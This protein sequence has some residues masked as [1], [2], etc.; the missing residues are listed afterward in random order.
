ME[1]NVFLSDR[2]SS[3]LKAIVYEF[4]ETGKPVGSRSFVQKYS[5]SISPATMRNIMFDLEKYG[6]LKQPHTS[7]GRI[8][9]DFGYRYYVDSLMQTYESSYDSEM[10]IKEDVLRREIQLDKMFVSIAKMLANV[11]KYAG[12]VLT[13]RADFTV[14]KY[15]ELVLLDTNE[16]LTVFVSRTGMILNKRVSVSE[17]L[18]QDNLHSYSKFLTSELS[19][20]SFKRIKESLLDSIRERLNN[21]TEYMIAVDIAE[22]SLSNCGEQDIYIE[23]IEN[24][25]H[26][27]E[28]LVDDRLKS[29][30]Y[31]IE[32][33]NNLKNII[34]QFYENDG[35]IT[36]IGEEIPDANVVDCS[37]ITSSYK[38][39]NNNVGALGIFGPTRMDYKKNLPLLDYTSK[40]VTTLLNKM[41]K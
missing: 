33:K 39:G 37:L 34:N 11:S 22:L 12:I 32:D 2:E 10:S 6:Y 30:L 17:A 15:I 26:I 23:G 16:V 20:Y 24:I 40:A 7:A 3:V 38:I 19:G 25:L 9:T 35:I 18:T 14:V 29:F 41:S 28:M 8:P 21:S 36:M 1:G 4:I 5:F 31:L 27:P 13:P